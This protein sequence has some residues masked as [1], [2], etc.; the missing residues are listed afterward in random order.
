MVF[1][2]DID[3]YIYEAH[4]KA[5]WAFRLPCCILVTPKASGHRAVSLSR[6]SIGF[7]QQANEF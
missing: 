4:I 7:S 3:M 6:I 2:Y 5:G 1:M